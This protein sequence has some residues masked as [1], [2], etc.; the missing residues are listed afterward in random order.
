MKNF[1]ICFLF[2]S[3]ILL[4]QITYNSS[5]FA[6]Q[7][8]S[9]LISTTNLGLNTF[10]FVSA[11]PNISWNYATLT[12]VS[13]ETI[14]YVNPTTTGYRNSW[15]LFNG[16]FFNCISQFNSNFNLAQNLTDGI[17]LQGIGLTNVFM[18]SKV[19]STHFENKMIGG[20]ITLNGSTI[21]VTVDYILPDIVYQF[22]MDYNDTFTNTSSLA[23]DLTALGVPISLSNTGE[24]TT[25]VEGWGSLTTPFG[26]FPNTL[27][28]KSTVVETTS[29]TN[30]GQTTNIP[31]TIVTY[32][33]FDT[34]YGIPVLEV[35]GDVIAGQWVPTNAVY[36][37]IQRCLEPNALF[38]FL[39]LTSDFD[40]ITQTASVSFINLSSNYDSL[41]WEFEDNST[42]TQTN[43][44][45]VFDCP[46]VKQVTLTVTN[47][48]CEPDQVDTITLPVTITDSQNAFSTTVSVD[49]ES[50]TADRSL[51]GTTYQWLD[52]D[53]GNQ[54]IQNATNLVFTPTQDGNYAVQLTTNGCTD[55]SDCVS[56]QVLSNTSFDSSKVALVPNP[57]NGL[58]YLSDASLQINKVSVFN[59]LGVKVASTLDLT[60]QA[61]GIYIVKLET[62]KGNFIKKVVK[63]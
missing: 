34:A 7:G 25:I 23:I 50:L 44:T 2:L 55:V 30:N 26:T 51:P 29:I 27:K 59:V 1:T 15:C 39:P 54:P 46:G 11:G 5:D 47:E 62:D 28:V 19:S 14:A 10:D 18:H 61:K 35:T 42:S 40:P 12:P 4:A 58:L 16:Y 49:I 9:Y 53:N 24:R 60:Q 43:P 3:Q 48:F 13:Q 6:T 45:Y 57:T 41:S 20:N 38:A 33:W 36:F 22:P 17:A 52:C 31:R 32:K 21:P 8:E 37:D 56:F 63:Q